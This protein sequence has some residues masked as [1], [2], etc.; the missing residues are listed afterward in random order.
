MGEFRAVCRTDEGETETEKK[1]ND[2][3]NQTDE[4]KCKNSSHI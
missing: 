2:T 1:M 4:E 3:E